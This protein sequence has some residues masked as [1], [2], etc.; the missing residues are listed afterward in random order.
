MVPL[1]KQQRE[2]GTGGFL[3]LGGEKEIRRRNHKKE[4]VLFLV[5]STRNP[6]FSRGNETETP[7]TTSTA[8]SFSHTDKAATHTNNL[9]CHTQKKKIKGKR[10]YDRREVEIENHSKY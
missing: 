1:L 2:R 8:K 10:D 3:N 4:N 6:K 5:G 7:T 9:I